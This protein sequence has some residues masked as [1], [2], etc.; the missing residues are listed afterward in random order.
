MNQLCEY[1]TSEYDGD[2]DRQLWLKFFGKVPVYLN[3]ALTPSQRLQNRCVS[4]DKFL[5]YVNNVAKPPVGPAAT[6][7]FEPE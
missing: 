5:Q 7:G 3:P 6:P 2:D 1:V 4:T